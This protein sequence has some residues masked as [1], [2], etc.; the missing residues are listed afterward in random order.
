MIWCVAQLILY[1]AF[2]QNCFSWNF[3]HTF[4][5]SPQQS[6][7]IRRLGE[8]ISVS[9]INW[10]ITKLNILIKVIQLLGFLGLQVSF[11]KLSLFENPRRLF[12]LC[13]Y[14]FLSQRAEQSL[15][16]EC[17]CLRRKKIKER[18]TNNNCHFLG[19]H[20]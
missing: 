12:C 18:G 13:F 6:H 8:I 17:W 15:W 11:S 2:T 3:S 7:K 1:F 10:E 9:E 14:M 16:S 19:S 5:L 4:F 20:L